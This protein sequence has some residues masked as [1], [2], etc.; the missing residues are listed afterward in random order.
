[1][2]ETMKEMGTAAS[3]AEVV[4]EKWSPLRWDVMKGRLDLDEEQL[5]EHGKLYAR[6]YAKVAIALL[7]LALLVFDLLAVAAPVTGM[8]FGVL[9]V[10]GAVGLLYGAARTWMSTRQLS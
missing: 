10:T 5:Q 7:C 2:S 4:I 3:F 9:S 1:M 6:S 8:L